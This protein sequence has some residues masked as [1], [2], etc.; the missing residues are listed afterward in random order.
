MIT[1]QSIPTDSNG[2]RIYYEI[3][4]NPKHERTHP[5]D[6]NVLP[7][8]LR[9]VFEADS[10]H[11]SDIFNYGEREPKLPYS[12][13]IAAVDEANTQRILSARPVARDIVKRNSTLFKRLFGTNDSIRKC[14]ADNKASL[15]MLE[16]LENEYGS[17][18]QAIEAIDD[19]NK[20]QRRDIEVSEIIDE[21]CVLTHSPDGY[22]DFRM[23]KLTPLYYEWNTSIHDNSYQYYMIYEM[24]VNG[25]RIT[26]KPR[27][28][29]LDSQ[30]VDVEELFTMT[31]PSNTYGKGLP[32]GVIT[33]VG[34]S[35]FFYRTKDAH[36]AVDQYR[37]R[38]INKLD[39]MEKSINL[40]YKQSCGTNQ[41][42]Y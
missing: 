5:I 40:M 1:M 10:R 27:N 18:K 3:I 37:S 7:F 4:K 22:V 34:N 9:P 24:E 31:S 11:I 20:I 30:C 13:A 8:I 26:V 32:H 23:E 28:S 19:S 25:K 39:I 14:V 33:V 16:N 36:N 21:V 41:F 15:N 29:K 6:I 2:S 12:E 35:I 38:L 42:P 17:I